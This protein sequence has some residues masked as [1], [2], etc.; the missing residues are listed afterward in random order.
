MARAVE[1]REVVALAGRFPVLARVDLSLEAGEVVVVAGPN[2]AGKT[3][4]LRACAGLLAVTSGEAT[5]LGCDLLQDRSSVRRQV[6]MLG[7]APALYDDLTVKENVSFAVRAAGA[8]SAEI[9]PTLERLGLGGRLSRTIAARLS[10]GQRRRVGL[11][12]IVARRPL[13]WLLDEPHAALDSAARTVLSELV[14]EAAARGAAVLLASHELAVSAP[15]AHRVVHMAGG[16]V[17]ASGDGGRRDDELEEP[18]AERSPL[19]ELPITGGAHV[20]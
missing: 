18:C 20:A 11:A 13:L 5:V 2:G 15:L 7:H 17:V 14:V 10:A 9:E 16:R 4:L 19:R 12:A 1:M 3:S 6:G 8:P